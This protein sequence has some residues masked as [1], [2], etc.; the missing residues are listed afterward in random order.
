MCTH[1]I[2][3]FTKRRADGYQEAICGTYV[4]LAQHVAPEQLPTCPR[5]R[6]YLED[7]D[8]PAAA[9]LGRIA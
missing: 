1:W 7:M 3:P 2:P 5:C 4:P 6:A 9:P 8:E